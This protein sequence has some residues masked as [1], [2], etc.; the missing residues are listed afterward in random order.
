MK[1]KLDKFHYHEVLDRTH[2]IRNI[3]DNELYNHPAISK[4][5]KKH[6]D[7]VQILLG[8]VYQLAGSRRDHK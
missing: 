5:M 7:K 1:D 3:I 6:I 2:M 4:K 8:K